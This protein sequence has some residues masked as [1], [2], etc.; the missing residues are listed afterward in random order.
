MSAATHIAR[1]NES[2]ATR[3][4]YHPIGITLHWVMAG[5]VLLQLGLGWAI[6]L[7]PAGFGK[8]EAYAVHT[9]VGVVLLLLALM[10]AGWR[11]IAPFILP[12]LEKPE[13]MPGWQHLAAEATHIM[14]YALMFALPLSGWLMLSAGERGDGLPL[15]GDLTW[16]QLPFVAELDF[17][18]RA[19][20]EQSAE[21]AHLAFVWLMIILATMHVGAALKHHFIDHDDVLSRMIPW[22][23]RAP[24]RP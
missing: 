15:P 2:E 1:S 13:D 21:A 17:V 7:M 20:L 10:R 8:L 5:L 11:C 9:A 3:P 22:L 14:L 24:D 19:H 6:T 16:P 23:A 4:H 12:D 18:A